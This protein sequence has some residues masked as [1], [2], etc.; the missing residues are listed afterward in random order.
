MDF[1]PAPTRWVE[2]PREGIQF[3][4]SSQRCAAQDNRFPRRES[5]IVRLLRRF[6]V[7]RCLCYQ[8]PLPCC[9]NIQGQKEGEACWE[10]WK[11]CPWYPRAQF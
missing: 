6:K 5:G 3:S 2:A 1:Y 10:F 7:Q 8:K 4:D 9:L 11:G